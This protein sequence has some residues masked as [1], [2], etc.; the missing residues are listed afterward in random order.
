[1]LQDGVQVYRHYQK[2]AYA[3]LRV[4]M[5]PDGLKLQVV[6]SCNRE[7][8]EDFAHCRLVCRRCGNWASLETVVGMVRSISD[9]A[10]LLTKTLTQAIKNYVPPL[11]EV[12][13]PIEAEDGDEA[14]E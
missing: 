1:M 14:G 5:R 12:E 7:M 11:E 3:W 10:K 13:E 9:Q 4:V 6:C 2:E 8:T